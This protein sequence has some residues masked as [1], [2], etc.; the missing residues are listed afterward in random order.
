MTKERKRRKNRRA[1]RIQVKNVLS[2]GNPTARELVLDALKMHEKRLV[3]IANE[4]NKDLL[5]ASRDFV[6]GTIDN[7]KR[8]KKDVK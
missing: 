8:W 5:G 1:R 6:V 7:V 2:S 3:D 4:R